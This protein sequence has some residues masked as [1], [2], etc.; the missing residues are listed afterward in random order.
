MAL[1]AIIIGGLVGFG[2]FVIALTYFQLGFLTALAIYSGSGLVITAFIL[3]M[4]SLPPV[5][6]WFRPRDQ[7]ALLRTRET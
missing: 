4:A 6:R 2:N 3:G 1:A 5:E 7:I